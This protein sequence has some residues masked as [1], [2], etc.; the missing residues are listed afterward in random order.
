[1]SYWSFNRDQTII[2]KA[3]NNI[4][5]CSLFVL[6]R[7]SSIYWS[8]R[9][10]RCCVRFKSCSLWRSMSAKIELLNFQIVF[11]ALDIEVL[12]FVATSAI[13][14]SSFQFLY[15]N[16]QF[17]NVCFTI[18]LCSVKYSTFKFMQFNIQ[19]SEM[20]VFR[21]PTASQSM[22]VSVGSANCSQ[23]TLH[24]GNSEAMLFCKGNPMG[25]IALVFLGDSCITWVTK[26][27]VLGLTVDHKLTWDAHLMDV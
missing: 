25:P 11:L 27:R 2:T 3:E 9:S 16:C 24:P 19:L 22:T 8:I 10:A 20:H 18:Q 7:L 26:A 4:T 12:Q 13:E 5:A 17:D 15:S 14:H 21:Y 1:M 6:T 23:L